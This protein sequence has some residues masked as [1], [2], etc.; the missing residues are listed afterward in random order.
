MVKILPERHFLHRLKTA[1][2]MAENFTFFV[3]EC[4]FLCLNAFN[5]QQNKG[6]F[7]ALWHLLCRLNQ[8][9]LSYTGSCPYFSYP[10]TL[11]TSHPIREVELQTTLIHHRS[12][13]LQRLDFCSHTSYILQH[14]V[15][16]CFCTHPIIHFDVFKVQ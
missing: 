12:P 16:R 15:S 1:F 2:W 8:R 4:R 13:V 5:D 7:A 6:L 14:C 11:N 10:L 3:I 9:F